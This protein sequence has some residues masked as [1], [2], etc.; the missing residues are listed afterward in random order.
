MAFVK[1]INN[2]WKISKFDC[3]KFN[4]FRCRKIDQWRR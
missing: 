1:S 3:L 4:Q 2:P